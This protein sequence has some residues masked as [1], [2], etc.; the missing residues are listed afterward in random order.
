MRGHCVES[1]GSRR[2]ARTSPGIT[3]GL[4]PDVRIPPGRCRLLKGCLRRCWQRMT[5][6]L[7]SAYRLRQ[8][9]E[10]WIISL[11]PTLD[12]RWAH[13]HGQR[14]APVQGFNRQ[15]GRWSRVLSIGRSLR[16]L[17][18]E[19]RSHHTIKEGLEMALE[20]SWT[21]SDKYLLEWVWNCKPLTKMKIYNCWTVSAAIFESRISEF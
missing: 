19:Y 17:C 12:R 21:D 2:G 8:A 9:S 1:G 4:V 20:T 10:H 13:R 16:G 7:S 15:R 14:A 6:L 18:L 3:A 11:G 5:R